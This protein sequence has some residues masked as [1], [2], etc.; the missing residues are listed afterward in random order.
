MKSL[1]FESADDLSLS[2]INAEL[3]I[4][5]KLDSQFV[6]NFFDSFASSDTIHYMLVFELCLGDLKQLIIAKKTNVTENLVLSLLYAALVGLNY[7][8]HQKIIHRDIKASNIMVSKN[9]E[10]KI[11][12][13]GSATMEPNPRTLIGTP[14]WIAP[15][16]SSDEPYDFKVDIW[17]LGITLIEISNFFPKKIFHII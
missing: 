17:S 5:S 4:L 14:C 10:V 15:E 9:F 3:K 12:D 1:N 8:H 6:V 7:L 11:G 2:K 13:F 16:V